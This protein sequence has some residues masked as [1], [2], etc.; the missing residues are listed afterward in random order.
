MYF[1][2]SRYNKS[3]ECRLDSSF[4]MQ[5]RIPIEIHEIIQLSGNDISARGGRSL[6]SVIKIADNLRKQSPHNRSS[7]L[8][9]FYNLWPHKFNIKAKNS[10]KLSNLE[11]IYIFGI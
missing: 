1:I 3:E 9:H 2:N 6:C 5:M 4:C 7:A 8:D 11:Y 10:R